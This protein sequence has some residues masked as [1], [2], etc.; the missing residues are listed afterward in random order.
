MSL[1]RLKFQE[2][3]NSV[4]H[5]M[6]THKMNN[7]N[8]ES[9]AS[10]STSTTASTASP[11][12]IKSE[13]IESIDIKME[14]NDDIE[15][16]LIEDDQEITLKQ[17]N[18]ENNN[19]ND[20]EMRSETP[21]SEEIRAYENKLKNIRKT[22]EDEQTFKISHTINGLSMV[23]SISEERGSYIETNIPYADPVFAG[24]LLFIFVYSCFLKNS[25]SFINH[26]HPMEQFFFLLF[27]RLFVFF[28]T[29]FVGRHK[30]I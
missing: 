24:T 19:I 2:H 9:L 4:E 12:E 18:D 15:T 5:K 20:I 8:E 14:Q 1:N 6:K 25:N 22:N 28:K 13:N 16:I 23:Q 21:L 10:T 3:L 17:E 7:L 26:P 11:S 27:I 29:N 30:T